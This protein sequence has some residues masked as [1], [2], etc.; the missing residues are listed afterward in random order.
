M[1]PIKFGRI[2]CSTVIKDYP[3][4][5]YV[6]TVNTMNGFRPYYELKNSQSSMFFHL[7]LVDPYVL[8][9]N[10][11]S[12]HTCLMRFP[13]IGRTCVMGFPYIGRTLPESGRHIPKQ[14]E[15]EIKL[16]T[17]QILAYLDR[18]MVRLTGEPA[19]KTL[20]SFFADPTDW[21]VQSSY[22]FMLT[23]IDNHV[24]S[25]VLSV[26]PF[27]RTYVTQSHPSLY[28]EDSELSLGFSRAV[29]KDI[30]CK[31]NSALDSVSFVDSLPSD[32]L[33]ELMAANKAN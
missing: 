9:S 20:I 24:K 26:K 19:D 13:Y 2:L 12:M 10:K 29:A 27:L 6:L 5:E 4:T 31:A 7:G 1:T 30:V 33:Y 22:D 14:Y 32:K 15:R 23:L 21:K 16:S 3:D 17:K 18:N 25:D 11:H 28:S 8:S